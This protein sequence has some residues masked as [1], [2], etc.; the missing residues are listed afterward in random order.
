MSAILSRACSA[1]ALL[2]HLCFTRLHALSC[3]HMHSYSAAAHL[4]CMCFQPRQLARS[5]SL[6][7][8]CHRERFGVPGYIG[9]FSMMYAGGIRH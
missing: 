1:S 3:F 7:R 5:R 2:V 6:A 4:H 9:T 8:H